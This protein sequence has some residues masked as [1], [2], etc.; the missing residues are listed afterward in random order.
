MNSA[1][2]CGSPLSILCLNFLSFLY[3]ASSVSDS[4]TGML[5]SG[6]TMRCSASVAVIVMSRDGFSSFS[7]AQKFSMLRI[8]R[9]VVDDMARTV[10]G[11][12]RSA[13]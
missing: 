9:P 13:S 3:R 4:G 8:T 1:A 5:L 6:F 2:I 10:S 12:L 7:S 11:S